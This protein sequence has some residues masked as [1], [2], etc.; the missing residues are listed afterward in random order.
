M[1]EIPKIPKLT[2]KDWISHPTTILLILVTVIAYTVTIIYVRSQLSQVDYLQSR[3]AKLETQ[4]DKYT[5]TIL[6]KE[7]TEKE[8]K[9]KLHAQRI[10]IDSLKG[11]Q[12]D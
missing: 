6:F 12:Y 9:D 1:S 10:E 3:V 11:G 2:L 5:N 7:A 8:L 4:L